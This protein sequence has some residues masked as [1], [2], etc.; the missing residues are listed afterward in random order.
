M[1][2]E[3]L[4]N[5]I[6]KKNFL[7][8]LLGITSTMPVVTIFKTNSS[9]FMVVLIFS[10]GFLVFDAFSTNTEFSFK[11]IERKLLFI[12]LILAL[13]SSICSIIFFSDQ[14]DWQTSSISYIYKIILYL[15]LFFL[16]LS[17]NKK[18]IAISVLKGIFIGALINCCWAVLDATFYY[19]FGESINNIVFQNYI[20]KNNI[21]Y[22]QLSL[23]LPTG[24]RASGFNSD[25]AHIG[26]LVPIVFGYGVYEKNKIYVLISVLTLLASMTTTGFVS[27]FLLGLFLLINR[28][29]DYKSKNVSKEKKIKQVLVGLLITIILL[30]VI[31]INL[32]F[33][34]RWIS[35]IG[36]LVNSFY[37]RVSSS[38]V[39]SQ[40]ENPREIYHLMLFSAIAFVGR[41]VIIGLGFGNSSYGYVM[42]PVINHR[43]NEIPRPYDVESTYISYLFDTG[44]FGFLFYMSLMILLVFKSWKNSNKNKVV[45]FCVF[46]LFSAQFFYHYI[47]S[48]SQML[49]I[50]CSAV[51]LSEFKNNKSYLEV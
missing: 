30:V 10:I 39:V 33:F 29:K 5:I 11:A 1:D 19:A 24:I 35:T 42:N 51:C 8:L 7:F 9:L 38:Y 2:G 43:L 25:P 14:I 18:N 20:I 27:C 23:I 41:M 45:F 46:S 17:Q 40:S 26:L 36:N 3:I 6:E 15:L 16:L 37:T 12:W 21:R 44:I 50:I 22:G 31:M 13:I 47:L 48:A 4:E 34:S 49:I 28:K 32:E